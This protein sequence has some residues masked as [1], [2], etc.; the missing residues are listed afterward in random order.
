VTGDLKKLQGTWTVVAL[1]VDGSTMPSAGSKIV[2]EGERFT[3][4]AMG[5]DYGGAVL[6]DP[7]KS[8]RTFDLLFDSGPHKGMK[9]LGIY[10]LDGDTWRI[11]LAFAGINTRPKEF[12]TKPGSGFA[13]ETLQRGDVSVAAGEP[14]AGAGPPTELEGEWTMVA[15][16]F[17]GH[18]MDARL[19]KQGRRIAKGDRLTVLFGAQVYLKA[20]VTLDPSKSPGHIDYAVTSGAA[21]GSTQLGVYQ[22]DAKKLTICM[23]PAG[24]PRPASLSGSPGGGL[25]LTVWEPAK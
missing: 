16:S 15:G 10:E 11:C 5:D 6:L 13:L 4:I 19:V 1:E 23:A 8:P 3:T 14:E 17:D 9:S 20:R 7:R 22:L 25:T 2:L 21:A 12:A 18:P 24:K